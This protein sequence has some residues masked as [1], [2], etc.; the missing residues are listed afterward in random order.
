MLT[1]RTLL[2]TAGILTGVAVA[3]IQHHDL[4]VS[5]PL[6]QDSPVR[7]A[8]DLLIEDRGFLNGA[9]ITWLKTDRHLDIMI[10]LRSDMIA[11]QEAVKLATRAKEWRPHPTRLDQAVAL[12]NRVDHVWDRCEV[13]LNACVIRF[14]NRRQKKQDHIVLATTDL[15]LNAAWIVRHYQ[16]RPEIEQD[17]EQLKSGG[18][19]LQK[20][21]TT[22]SSEIV[23]YLL[24]ILLS[25]SLS[26]LFANTKTGAR[27]ADKTRQALAL[28]QLCT[29]R[30]HVIVYAGGFFELY[31]TRH[32][33]HLV[34]WNIEFR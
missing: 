27:F 6:L 11:F 22:R 34:L 10:P 2:D 9:L 24:T 16:E 7:R 1:L 19:L 13:P 25:Y 12:V 3:P 33:L 30:T 21:S 26:H 5:Q 32:F 8:G 20:L 17:Y 23:F 14:W 28:E 29:R 18:W 15:G 31:E 4:S